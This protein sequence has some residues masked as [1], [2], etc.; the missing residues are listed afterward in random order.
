MVVIKK[1]KDVDSW[2]ARGELVDLTE[3]ADSPVVAAS[4][5]E[6]VRRR[7]RPSRGKE[8]LRKDPAKRRR[9]GEKKKRGGVVEVEV[10]SE[11]EKGVVTEKGVAKEK[12][13]GVA[14]EKEKGVAKEKGVVEKEKGATTTNKKT[15]TEKRVRKKT[16]TPSDKPTQDTPQ[17]QANGRQET[18]LHTEQLSLPDGKTYMIM[19]PKRTSQKY[20]KECVLW[21]NRLLEE[22]EKAE[23]MRKRREEMRRKREQMKEHNVLMHE[24]ALMTKKEKQEERKKMREAGEVSSA[25]SQKRAEASSPEQAMK[26]VMSPPEHAKKA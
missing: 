25:E 2:C 11:K 22:A 24:L 15:T 19:N 13:K 10:V 17:L 6:E 20:L 21:D 23:K 16:N 14:K 8:T 7:E 18:T 5:V 9:G 1:R 12:E 26:E 3:E 4:G